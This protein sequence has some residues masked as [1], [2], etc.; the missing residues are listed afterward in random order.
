MSLGIVGDNTQAEV[1][2]HPGY[3]LTPCVCARWSVLGPGNALRSV[4]TTW[5]GPGSRALLIFSQ[6]QDIG[7]RGGQ[8]A[9]QGSVMHAVK[10]GLLSKYYSFTCLHVTVDWLGETQVEGP[11]PVHKR[12]NHFPNVLISDPADP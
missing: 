12:Q 6:C 8:R 4:A 5:P 11:V 1:T 7:E 10:F 2:F 9:I 3:V